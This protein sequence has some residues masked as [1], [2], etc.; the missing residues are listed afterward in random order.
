MVPLEISSTFS[1]VRAGKPQSA[2]QL[3][4]RQCPFTVCK[5]MTFQICQGQ[6]IPLGSMS[7]MQP[8]RGHIDHRAPYVGMS[9]FPSFDSFRMMG[10]FDPK[11]LR[12]PPSQTLLDEVEHLKVIALETKAQ[13]VEME[14][15]FEA[16]EPI[17]D[18]AAT[19]EGTTTSS[20]AP[21]TKSRLAPVVPPIRPEA[22][23]P[24]RDQRPKRHR[25][26]PSPS[27]GKKPSTL[28][29]L[30]KSPELP[31]ALRQLQTG[32]L[33]FARHTAGNSVAMGCLRTP[34]PPM[35]SSSMAKQVIGSGTS[36][37]H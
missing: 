37:Q 20:A 22:H 36:G 11:V 7:W 8:E 3:T 16:G 12:T 27:S 13:L 34:T 1:Q 14:R 23:G 32:S 5:A 24:A 4:R 29:R 25:E 28:S 21:Q 35:R 18:L 6:T 15:R 17:F 10:D 31:L 2:F 33:F 9:R 19:G 26:S 30:G